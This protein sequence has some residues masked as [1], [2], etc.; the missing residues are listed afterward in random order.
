MRKSIFIILCVCLSFLFVGASSAEMYVGA[1]LGYVMTTDTDLTVPG[2]GTGT[3]EWDGGFGFGAALGTTLDAFR[4][5]GEIEYRSADMKTIAETDIS[6]G[7]DIKTLSLMANGYYDFNAGTS[8][9]PYIGVGIGFARHTFGLDAVIY[10]EEEDEDIVMSGEADDTVFAYQG[11]IGAAWAI[12]DTMDLDCAYRYFA[13]ADPDFDGVEAGY[14][15]HNIS[16]G[17]RFKF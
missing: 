3:V 15:S 9:K 6:V 1:K 13:T 8:F 11:T 12:S 4:I 14:A 7:G 17:L 16:L 2:L 10:D 5:E